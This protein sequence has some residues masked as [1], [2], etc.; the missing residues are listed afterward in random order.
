M[1]ALLIVLVPIRH[2]FLEVAECS[3]MDAARLFKLANKL[4]LQSFKLKDLR[5]SLL[6]LEVA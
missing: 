3:A 1:D 4:L 5:F 6:T 2:D